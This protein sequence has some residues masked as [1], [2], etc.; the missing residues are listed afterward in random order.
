MRKYLVLFLFIFTIIFV[1]CSKEP[2]KIDFKFKDYEDVGGLYSFRI[3]DNWLVA[4]TENSTKFYSSQEAYNKFADPSSGAL[5]VLM[6][7]TTKKVDYPNDLNK[8]VE[9]VTQ[10]E[11]EVIPQ[12]ELTTDTKFGGRDAKKMVYKI[13]LTSSLIVE[14]VKYVAMYDSILYNFDYKVFHEVAPSYQPALDTIVNSFVLT[15]PRTGGAGKLELPSEK[16]ERYENNLLGVSYPNNFNTKFPKTSFEFT[17]NFVGLRQD[18]NFQIDVFPSKG[19][20]VEKIVEQN[21]GKYS[22]LRGTGER[23][24]AGLKGIYLNYSAVKNI[25]S[26]AYFVVKG[27]KVYRITLNW[28]VE[29]EKNYLPVFEK[30]LSSLTLK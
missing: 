3:P 30:M 13:K 24:I 10:D 20:S 15:Q 16:F 22:G 12:Y 23:Q 9:F 25:S 28:H 29:E 21:K 8:A 4:P 1:S 26:R 11:K 27:E 14:G 7:V 6:S 5:G 19:L 2:Q 18:C 17:G